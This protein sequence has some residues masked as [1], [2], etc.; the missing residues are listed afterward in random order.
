[1]SCPALRSRSILGLSLAAAVLGAGPAVRAQTAA[2]RSQTLHVGHHVDPT[3]LHPLGSTTVAFESVFGNVVEKLVLFDD[4]RATIRPNLA[5]SWRWVDATTLELK[6]VEGVRFTNGEPMDAA[7]VKWSLEE[8]AQA[9]P[10]LAWTKGLFKAVQAV[11]AHTVRIVATQP[12]PYLLPLL[13][14]GGFVM[15][16]GHHRAVGPDRYGQA[17]VGTGPFVFK[18]WIKDSRITLVRNPGFRGGPHPLAEVVFRVIVEDTA[19]TAAL[20]AGELD[21]A[22]NVPVSHLARLR[23]KPQVSVRLVDGLRKFATYFDTS[24]PPLRDPRVRVAMNHAVDVGAIVTGLFQGA[25]TAMPGQWQLPIERGHNPDIKAHGY[26][27]GKAR[28]LLAAAGH[29]QGFATELRYTVGRYPLDKELGE[30]VAS[31][32][33]QVGIR[34]KQVPLEYGEFL[35]QRAAKQLGPLHQWGLLLTPDPWFNYSLFAKGTIYRFVDYPDRWD[36]LIARAARE[37]SEER[38]A[39]LYHELA[40]M[41][42]DE[43]FAIYLVVPKDI[44]ATSTR[45]QG[46]APRIDQALLLYGVRLAP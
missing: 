9:K 20:E 28:A 34:V 16:P 12:A 29:P 1:M 31:Y 39:A 5:R 4:T 42:H 6:L 26:D 30:I 13:A 27:P 24:V 8:L 17:P 22:L 10:Y 14:R 43:P 2:P 37:P 33:E 41:S 21:L 45:V 19:R 18:E 7:A 25:A 3:T 40:R 11:D 15:P 35:R 38:Q 46:F 44:Y 32:L 36:E 23:G